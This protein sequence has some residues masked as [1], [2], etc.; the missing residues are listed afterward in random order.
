MYLV[1]ERFPLQTFLESTHLA[2]RP[3]FVRCREES[4]LE[5]RGVSST[6]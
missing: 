4:G 5:A 1:P 2:F 3:E 6:D